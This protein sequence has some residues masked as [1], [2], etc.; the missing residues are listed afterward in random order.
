VTGARIPIHLEAGRVEPSVFRRIHLPTNPEAFESILSAAKSG[1]EWAWASLYQDLAGPVRGYLAS[2]GAHEPDDVT[3]EV[4]L[5]VAGAIQR[6][7]GDE[8]SFRSWIFVIAHRRLID[9]RRRRGRQPVITELSPATVTDTE[10]GNVEDEAMERLSTVEME[11]MLAQLTDTQRDVLALRMIGGLSLEQTAEV[12]GKRV[13]AVK[14][15]QHRA[16]ASLQA[17]FE[18]EGISR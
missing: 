14:A 11:D 18:T 4:F 5:K 7:E 2:R 15:L 9:E 6:F 10:I 13:G 1:A 3:S 16:L 8:T 17:K 12:M